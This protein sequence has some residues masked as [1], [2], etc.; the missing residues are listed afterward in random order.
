VDKSLAID[1]V[2]FFMGIN[3]LM[4]SGMLLSSWAAPVWLPLA[5]IAVGFVALQHLLN[6]DWS[7]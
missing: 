1:G 6:D 2:I 5:A 3:G 4:G 7:I